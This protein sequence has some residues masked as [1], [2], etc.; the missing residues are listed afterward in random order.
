MA[1]GAMPN[2]QRL[3][4]KSCLFVCRPPVELWSLTGLRDVE[5]LH[6]CPLLKNVLQ[7]LQTRDECKLQV[8]PPL[9]TTM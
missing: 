3:V 4:I 7:Q 6:P 5:V 2:L 8:N 1:K 9:D